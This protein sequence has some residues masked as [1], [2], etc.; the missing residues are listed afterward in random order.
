MLKENFRNDMYM[1]GDCAVTIVRI[2][3]FLFVFKI[4]SDVIDVRFDSCQI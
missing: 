2:N 4:A 1:S 3:I